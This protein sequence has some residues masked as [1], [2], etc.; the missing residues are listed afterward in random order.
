[1]FSPRA[2]AQP[3]TLS[4]SQAGILTC[5]PQFYV[6]YARLIK[7]QTKLWVLIETNGY[8]LTSQNLDRLQASGVDTFHWMPK[9]KA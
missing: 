3:G 1:M 8:G 4:P 2:L 5:C 7:T 9:H 6:E